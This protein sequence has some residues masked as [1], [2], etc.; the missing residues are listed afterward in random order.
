MDGKATRIINFPSLRGWFVSTSLAFFFF[1]LFVYR[2][3]L[4]QTQQSK[5]LS[6][7]KHL[8]NWIRKAHGFNYCNFFN[9]TFTSSSV[10][11]N[12]RN[13]APW[14]K[15]FFV[16]YD[17]DWKLHKKLNEPTLLNFY[18]RGSETNSC[19]WLKNNLLN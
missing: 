10:G 1:F 13:N 11:A 8:P 15:I 4:C 3:M 14:H 6:D 18:H 7:I 16:F 2:V 5:T 9:H 19:T 17:T 12:K